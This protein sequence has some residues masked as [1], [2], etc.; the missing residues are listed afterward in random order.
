MVETMTTEQTPEGELI[1][2]GQRLTNISTREAARQAGISEGRWRQIVKGYQAVSAGTKVP[3][4]APPDTLARMANVVG[5]TPEQLE[6]AG[7][8]DAA[9]SH[10]FLFKAEPVP[11]S[12]FPEGSLQYLIQDHRG[13]MSYAR[14]A[15]RS[16]LTGATSDRAIH[17][18]ANQPITEFPKPDTIKGLAKGLRV[19]VLDVIRAAA[20]SLGIEVHTAGDDL[21]IPGAGRLPAKSRELLLNMAAAL[22]DED[23]DGWGLAAHKGE[24]GVDPA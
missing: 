13:D 12:R 21:V 6:D 18:L 24:P 20:V 3:V 7:R 10:R 16:G 19:P 5:V 23:Q 1:A 11:S 8:L 2:K 9:E 22:M 4:T 17:K 14:L 15:A